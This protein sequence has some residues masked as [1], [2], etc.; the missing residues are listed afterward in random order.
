MWKFTIGLLGLISV[1]VLFRLSISADVAYELAQIVLPAVGAI[2]IM[3][4]AISVAP[5]LDRNF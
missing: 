5:W 3:G 2:V 4:L 1:A